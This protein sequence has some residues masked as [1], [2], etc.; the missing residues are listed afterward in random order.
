L[1]F[2]YFQNTEKGQQS[3]PSCII[4]AKSSALAP[5]EI[6]EHFF[7]QSVLLSSA[8]ALENNIW[9]ENSTKIQYA[10]FVAL[11]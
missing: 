5:M 6:S 3:Q 2:H 9:N 10:N 1:L 4:T 8:R 11:V 7:L